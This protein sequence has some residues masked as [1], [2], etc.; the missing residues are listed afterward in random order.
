MAEIVLEQFTEL[1]LFDC[2]LNTPERVSCLP[3]DLYDKFM[4]YALQEEMYECAEKLKT[5]EYKVVDKTLKEFF[6]VAGP[7]S[8]F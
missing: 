5:L 3:R 8:S 7:W 6:D 4:D 2:V 1:T